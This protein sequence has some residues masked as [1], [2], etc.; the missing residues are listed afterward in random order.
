MDSE[1][2]RWFPPMYLYP[3]NA[4]M[5]SNHG[6]LSHS[7]YNATDSGGYYNHTTNG[8]GLPGSN[9]DLGTPRTHN[10]YSLY[11]PESPHSPPLNSSEGIGNCPSRLYL[12]SS[13]RN[14]SLHP[15]NPSYN[16][17]SM[18]PHMPSVAGSL[19]LPQFSSGHNSHGKEPGISPIVDVSPNY[20]QDEKFKLNQNTLQNYPGFP[21]PHLYPQHMSSDYQSS[22]NGVPFDMLSGIPRCR[23]ISRSNSG[24]CLTS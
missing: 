17:S 13:C 8:V 24:K 18:W 15:S 21:P 5:L 12:P 20:N 4:A 6:G 11:H 14:Q 10:S 19:S 23:T 22:V 9:S 3:E 1:H 7:N 16:Q 2:G